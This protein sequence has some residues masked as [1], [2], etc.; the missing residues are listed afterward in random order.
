MSIGRITNLMT[1]NQVLADIN[2][3]QNRLDVTQ[4]QLS[5]GKKIL[6]PSDD[7]YG[8]SR[9]VDLNGELSGLSAYSSNIS[10]GTAWATAS[11]TALTSIQN[12]VQ[13]VREL[14]VEAANGTNSQSNLQSINAEITQLTA[15]IKQSANA[16]YNG[17]YLFAGSATQ[18][19]PYTTA[20]DVYQGNANAVNRQIGPGT[21]L[22]VNSDISSVL[23]SGQTANDGKLL[24]VLA[25][26]SSDLTSGSTTALANLGTTDLSGLDTNLS[27]LSQVQSANG[28]TEN[29]LTLAAT[30]ISSLQTSDTAALSDVQDADYASTLTTFSNEQ[31]AFTAALKASANIVQSSLIDFLQ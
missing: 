13:R 14:V 27:T 24:N 1:T 2:D 15:S 30:R 11:D 4:E 21:T 28:A 9:A 10:D 25:N 26:I 8:A 22:Q 5:S 23:G 31:A 19:A 29:R 3:A 18:T 7:P 20:S 17:Q 12:Q 16:Q 6:Q